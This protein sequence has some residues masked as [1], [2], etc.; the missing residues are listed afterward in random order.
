MMHY[1]LLT[2]GYQLPG[3]G[4]GKVHKKTPLNEKG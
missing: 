4:E 1:N 3:E 2:N